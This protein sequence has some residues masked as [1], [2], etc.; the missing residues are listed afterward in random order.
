MSIIQN[1]IEIFEP[2]IIDKKYKISKYKDEIVTYH[3]SDKNIIL[4]ILIKENICAINNNDNIS[5]FSLENEKIETIS[6]R[7]ILIIET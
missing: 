3:W 1:F 5:W 2:N 4:D 7:L 6:S